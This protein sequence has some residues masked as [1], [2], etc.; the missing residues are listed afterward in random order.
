MAEQILTLDKA[1][2]ICRAIEKAYQGMETLVGRRQQSVAEISRL[3]GENKVS[4]GK[5]QGLKCV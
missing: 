3:Q 1:I 4:R 5:G 2:C